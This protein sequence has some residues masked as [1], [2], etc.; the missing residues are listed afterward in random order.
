[1]ADATA[2]P[3]MAVI[4]GTPTTMGDTTAS[5]GM[6]DL[7]SALASAPS[8]DLGAIPTAMDI[9]PRPTRPTRMALTAVLP[10]IPTIGTILPTLR[11]TI[12]AL[13]TRT[14]TI[15]TVVTT[16]TR[17][18]ATRIMMTSSGRQHHHT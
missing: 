2:I 16:A 1:M 12:A 9:I 6:E 13:V 3:I 11:I 18:R 8:G 15:A 5:P 17:A 4:T 14:P 10:A 7:V